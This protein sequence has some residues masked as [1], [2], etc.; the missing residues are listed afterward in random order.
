[1][2]R[3][4]ALADVLTDDS[5]RRRHVVDAWSDQLAT[6]LGFTEQ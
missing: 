4:L 1:M 3:G 6:G 5:R 2:A